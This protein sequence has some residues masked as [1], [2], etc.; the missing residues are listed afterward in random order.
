MITT[1][2]IYD[3]NGNKIA[4]KAICKHVPILRWRDVIIG[5]SVGTLIFSLLVV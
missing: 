5:A 1:L 2:V 4:E 3:D